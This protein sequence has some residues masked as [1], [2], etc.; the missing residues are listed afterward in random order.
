MKTTTALAIL[1][2]AASPALAQSVGEKSGVNSVLG[3]TPS[4]EDFV[5]QAAQSDMFEIQSSQLASSQSDKV[6][7]F[8]QQMIEAHTKTTSELKSTAGSSA[9]IPS[10]MSSSQK[11]MLDD[12][13]T[14]KGDDLA[15]QYI[16]DQVSAHKDA[17]SLFQRYADGGDKPELKAWAAKTLPDLQHHLEMAQALDK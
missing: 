15:N 3:V 7:D 9:T 4:T 8:A 5:L 11:S 13:K 10:D 1:L 2:L 14:R 6:K 12:L 16:D 17:V